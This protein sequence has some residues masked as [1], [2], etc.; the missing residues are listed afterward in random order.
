MNEWDGECPN[1]AS[2]HH[3]LVW[4]RE[5]IEKIHCTECDH[6]FELCSIWYLIED[7]IIKAPSPA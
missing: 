2:S 3:E 1:C 7:S 5:C 4:H 6:T